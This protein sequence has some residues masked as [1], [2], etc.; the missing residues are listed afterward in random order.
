LLFSI[1]QSKTGLL[2]L[3][4]RAMFRMKPID[5]KDIR[6]VTLYSTRYTK[7]G[8]L[9]QETRRILQ[10]LCTG[11]TLREVRDNV[12]GGSVIPQ[13]SRNTRRHI[14]SAFTYRFLTDSPRWVINDL[15]SAASDQDGKKLLSLNYLYFCLRDQLTFDFVTNVIW[16]N[17][18]TPNFLLSRHDVLSFLDVASETQPHVKRWSTSTRSKLA[19]MVLSA[20]R[21]F[22][23]LEGSQ[24]KRVSIPALPP[25]TVVHLMRI[26]YC[27]GL[28]RDE[29]FDAPH[30]QLFLRSQD[31]ILDLLR[32]DPDTWGIKFERIGGSIVFET[33]HEWNDP[34]AI[35]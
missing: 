15:I 21:D 22:Q 28:K 31:S 9:V 7:Q 29:V 27:S 14:W 25:S 13:K 10:E 18:A 3:D 12:L 20:L 33:P 32:T 16:P 17:R 24:R 19:S 8:A 1:S 26:L 23:V 6:E 4:V 30:W 11:V 34:N 5:S 2:P 35:I